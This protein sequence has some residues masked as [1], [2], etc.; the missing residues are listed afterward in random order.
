MC[1]PNKPNR[2]KYY[3]DY[4]VPEETLKDHRFN[5][6]GHIGIRLIRNQNTRYI[7]FFFSIWFINADEC[8]MVN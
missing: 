3:S 5:F 8:L 6:L 1:R 7:F 4:F 2:E